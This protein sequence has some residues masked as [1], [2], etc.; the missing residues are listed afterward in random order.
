MN[1]RWGIHFSLDSQ[2]FDL[3]HGLVLLPTRRCNTAMGVVPSGLVFPALQVGE[4]G[5]VSL[6]QLQ[7]SFELVM[8]VG[9]DRS[10]LKRC[11][12]RFC[13][14]GRTRTI[15]RAQP[16]LSQP[17]SNE[18]CK[19]HWADLIGLR[20]RPAVMHE[21]L[22]CSGTD[23]HFHCAHRVDSVRQAF[24]SETTIEVRS[25]LFTTERCSAGGVRPVLR[26]P[27]T[28][29]MGLRSFSSRQQP[30]SAIINWPIL[31]S[32]GILAMQAFKVSSLAPAAMS[33]LLVAS[34]PGAL[35]AGC[36]S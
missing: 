32:L 23:T 19:V 2:D 10:R 16:E 27:G 20:E 6:R 29:W 12:I 5:Q 7:D 35:I 1:G 13:L 14:D 11:N 24:H 21:P 22:H 18:E 25:A 8:Q 34:V 33:A 15:S 3:P 28:D 31:A 30:C 9:L 4:P 26:A 17:V 36:R